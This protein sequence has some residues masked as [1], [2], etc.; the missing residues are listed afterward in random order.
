[1]YN[2]IEEIYQ[3]LRVINTL[4]NFKLYLLCLKLA[5]YLKKLH[6]KIQTLG[7]RNDYEI[8]KNFSGLKNKLIKKR[9]TKERMKEKGQKKEER[10]RKTKRKREKEYETNL[11]PSQNVIQQSCF[12]S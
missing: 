2:N 10:E 12:H 8:T 1:M 11:T 5:K 4:R 7:K 9:G 3:K 6:K